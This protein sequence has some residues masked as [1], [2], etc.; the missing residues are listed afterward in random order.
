MNDFFL[1]ANRSVFVDDIEVRQIQMK[2]FD[3]WDAHAKQIKSALES[4]NY[5]DEILTTLLE[6]NGL[7]AI[8]SLSIVCS[9][10]AK[11]LLSNDNLLS[12]IRAMLTVNAVYFK[13]EKRVRKS[14]AASVDDYT[15]F[16]S[17][18]LLVGAGH[19]H[20]SIMN[21]TYG[22]YT[23]YLKSAQKQYSSRLRAMS[24]VV[25]CA[26]HADRKGFEKFQ[27]NLQSE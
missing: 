8:M 21:M 14:Q 26:Q 7:A 5:S 2:E 23:A 20:E 25:R 15:W 10:A 3:L 22:A 11:E 18:Q 4:E 9:I 24:N 1:A 17:F 16:D 19:S 13:K 6:A 27:Q 12:L